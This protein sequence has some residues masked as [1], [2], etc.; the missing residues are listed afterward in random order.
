MDV[1]ELIELITFVLASAKGP[2]ELVCQV[3]Q[4]GG[5]VGHLAVGLPL[6]PR[7]V[8]RFAGAARSPSCS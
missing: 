2:G 7:T 5:K 3:V 4:L 6:R 1:H 8:T